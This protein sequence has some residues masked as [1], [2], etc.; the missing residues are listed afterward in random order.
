[1][2]NG[3]LYSLFTAKYRV[4]ESQKHGSDQREKFRDP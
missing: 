4:F 2:E 1:V 3:E